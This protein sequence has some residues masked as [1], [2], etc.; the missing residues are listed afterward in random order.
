MVW[1]DLNAGGA[2]RTTGFWLDLNGSGRNGAHRVFLDY[3]RR[4]RIVLCQ[5]LIRS[6]R[7]PVFLAR[8]CTCTISIHL[9]H[10]FLSGPQQIAVGT[11]LCVDS[12]RISPVL[13]RPGIFGLWF[14]AFLFGALQR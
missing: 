9:R 2:A 4:P 8:L 3:H 6:D 12:L 14:R 1:S 10:W 7:D 13:N 11:L 5:H